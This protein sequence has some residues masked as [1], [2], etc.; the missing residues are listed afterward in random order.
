MIV[1]LSIIFVSLPIFYSIY[2]GYRTSKEIKSSKD[3]FLF[4]EELTS[5]K[6]RNSITA[7]NTSLAS[8]IFSFLALGYSFKIAAILSPITWLAGFYIL[9]WFFPKIKELSNRTLHGYLAYKYDKKWIGFIASFASIIG[10]LGTYGIELLVS[11]KISQII[12]PNIPTIL[13]AILLSLVVA[14]YTALGGFKSATQLDTFRL[15]LTILGL[16][17]VFGFSYGYAINN[18]Q[19][20]EN[21]VKVVTKDFYGFSNLTWLFVI[22]LMLLNVPWQI[23]DMSMWQKLVACNNIS[24]ITRG[25][26]QSIWAIGILWFLLIVLGISLN[27]FPGFFSPPNDDYATLFLSYLKSPVVFAFF[28]MGCIAAMLSTA[29][30]LLIASVQTL[31]QDVV[32]PKRFEKLSTGTIDNQLDREILLFG[33]RWVFILGIISPVIIYLL[34]L[35]IPG[36]LD[37]FF[38]VYTAQLTLLVSICV[39]IF[40]K[41]PSKFKEISLW[42]ICLGLL[43]ALFMLIWIVTHPSPNLFL[44]APIASVGLS[45]IPW[46]FSSI[47][48][49]KK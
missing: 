45:I 5:A 34:N 11:I 7:S 28:A 4:H 18:S 39:A 30:S 47:V 46:I 32:F 13:I 14:T 33:R 19:S 25:L 9:I 37:L 12:F 42:S 48:M 44:W 43:C 26:K 6:L 38:L 16:V 15:Y 10:F 22:S 41:N 20:F 8:V 24:D 36:I 3:F 27:F 2:T 31:A 17:V 21:I 49:N 35:L 23:V 1:V 40:C 29:D